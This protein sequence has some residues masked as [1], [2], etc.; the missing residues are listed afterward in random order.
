MWCVGVVMGSVGIC[1]YDNDGVEAQEE[2]RS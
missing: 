2:N 1:R